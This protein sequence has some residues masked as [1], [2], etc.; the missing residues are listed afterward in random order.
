M[1]TFQKVK[2]YIGLCAIAT[3][4]GSQTPLQAKITLPCFF[5]DNMIIQ[6]KTTMT[7]F[8]KAKANKK[9]TVETGWNNQRYETKADKEGNWRIAVS[10]PEAGGPYDITL[11]DGSKTVLKNVMAGEVWFCSGQSNMEMPLAGWGKIKN[12][13]QEIAAANYPDIRLFQVKKR[14]SVYPL[15]YDQLE[16][17][18]N[19]WQEC[20]P[21][22]VHNFSAL[23]YL[24]ARELQ[25]KL[26]I[27]IGVIDCTWGGT[28]AE[29]WTSSASLK[30]VIGF[31]EQVARLEALGFD[32]D[33]VM[34]DYNAQYAEWLAKANNIDKGYRN[35]KECLVDGNVN[36]KDWK[37]M[38]LP[39]FWEGNGMPN[40][41]GIVWFR[42]QVEIPADW[43]N[44][45][46]ELNLGMIDDEDI[47]YWNGEAFAKGAGYNS[48]RRYTVPA[49]LVKQ[50]VNTIAIKVTDTGG[51][52]GIGGE[53]K[54]MNIR[55][56]DASLS[57]AG[58]WKYLV[59]CSISDLPVAPIYPE[60]SSFPSVLFN[61]MVHPCLEYPVK[62]AIWYQGCNN[63]GRA[64]EYESLFQ[65]LIND[66]RIQFKQPE[67][68]FYFVQLANYLERK[69]VQ[70]DSPWAALREAQSKAKHL[71]NTGMVVNIEI[72]EAYDIHPKNKQ[73]VARRLA[74]ISLADTYGQK[75]PAE[76]PEY[77]TYSVDKDGKVRISFTISEIGEN[78]S[79]NNDI[80]GFTIAGP[81]HV[82]YPAKAYTDGNQVVVSSPKVKMPV[83]VRYG[84]ADNPECT[85]STPSNLPVAPFRTDNWK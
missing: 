12:Y 27:P 72:G 83:A 20:S 67:M 8:G 11:S 41:D 36:D 63:V 70:A 78:F 18:M 81:D 79:Q 19:G 45:D 77:S 30:H 68:P 60:H 58:N 52:G 51:G 62:G 48:H 14:T 28:P 5:T 66:W 55:L 24:Y 32:R 4:V 22:T 64:V 69:E 42:K 56:K 6:Q 15:E 49:R 35:G 53:A 10:T 31:Q 21:N 76:A 40:F 71:D 25:Q 85:L 29:A 23:A 33:K 61:G 46:L 3:C 16:S 84:W 75:V 65:T 17:T 37:Q 73:E 43:T 38:Q 47:V 13:E 50:G 1:S 2:R 82:F 7:L 57:L 59:G 39:G 9:V 80:K 74:A 44:K 26:N 54:D 34:A